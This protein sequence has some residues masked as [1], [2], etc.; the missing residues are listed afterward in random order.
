MGAYLS[1]PILEKHSTDENGEFL[2]FGASSMQGWRVSQEVRF[3]LFFLALNHGR[4]RASA[5]HKTTVYSRKNIMV[6][7][8]TVRT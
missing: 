8:E 7:T 3:F 1:E 5:M 4:I 2:S 6:R